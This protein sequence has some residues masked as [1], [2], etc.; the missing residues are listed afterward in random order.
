MSSMIQI[1]KAEY[2]TLN[3]LETATSPL[4]PRRQVLLAPTRG[5]QAPHPQFLRWHRE[6]VFKG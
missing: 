4:S 3:P 2:W 1:R 6:N 5:D